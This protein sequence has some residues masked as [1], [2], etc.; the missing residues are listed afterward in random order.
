MCVE[1]GFPASCNSYYVGSCAA[2]PSGKK[3]EWDGMSCID[4][5]VQD[6]DNTDSDENGARL[7]YAQCE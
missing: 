2:C 6:G 4:D 5:T 3:V 7:Y 1:Q